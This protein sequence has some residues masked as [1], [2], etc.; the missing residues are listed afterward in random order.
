M[1]RT[2]TWASLAAAGALALTIAT[3]AP[4]QAYDST[5]GHDGPGRTTVVLNPSLVPTLV[6]TLKV[7]ALAPGRLDAPGGVA[8]VSFPITRV[9]DGVVSHVGGLRFTPVGGGDLRITHFDVNLNTGYLTAKTRLNGAQVGRVNIF[10][11]GA[12]QPING[13][14]PA[15][16]GVA[17]G[18]TLTKDAATALGAP[19]F[20]GAFVGDACVV[21]SSGDDED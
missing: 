18:L 17:A 19:S 8:Q 7:Q 9:S 14:A 10:A 12:V 2:R 16:A 6:G 4:A 5:A 15:C 11:L 3:A 13:S 20:A 1:T 21:P